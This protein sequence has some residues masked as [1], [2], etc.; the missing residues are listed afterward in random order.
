[1][2]EQLRLDPAVEALA[3]EA[4]A[5]PLG[6]GS[7]LDRHVL[8]DLQRREREI[9]KKYYAIGQQIRWKYVA[10]TLLGFGVWLSVFPLTMLGFLPLLPAFVFS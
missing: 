3:P 1:M 2:S 8:L 7:G 10:A 4:P 5:L 9:A 6:K